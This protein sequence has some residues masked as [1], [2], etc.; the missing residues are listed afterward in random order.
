VSLSTEV[1]SFSRRSGLLRWR[2][3]LERWRALL[4]RWPWLVPAISFAAGWIGFALVQRGYEL[5]RLVALLAIVGWPWLLLE[6]L[7]RRSL[8]RRASGRISSMIVN[9]ITQSLQQELLFFSLPL[10]IGAAQPQLGQVAFVALAAGA[11]LLS[12]IDPL[13]ERFVAARPATSLLFHAYCSWIAALTLL[14]I[15]LHLPLERALPLSLGLVGIW[16]ILA[17]PRLLASLKARRERMAWL[18]LLVLLPLIPWALRGQIPAAGLS[19][20]EGRIT[21]V[22]NGLE[23]GQGISRLRADDLARGVVAFVAIRAPMGVAQSIVF[24]WRHGADSERIRSEIHGGSKTG[25]RTY[26]RK[27]KFPHDATGRW[28]VRVLTPQGQLLRRMV[29]DVE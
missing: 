7:I 12:T 11:A 19:V 23:P 29:F 4:Q 28:E 26:S 15:V 13:Y 22:L 10:L 14:P 24:E 16:L 5:A 20:G 1:S 3:R 18:L 25:W 27:Q 2:Q 17:L 9:F 8:L 21:Q 6:P